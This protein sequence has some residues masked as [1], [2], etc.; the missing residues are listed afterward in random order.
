MP[1]NGALSEAAFCVHVWMPVF[2]ELLHSQYEL[3]SLLR[4]IVLSYFMY[5]FNTLSNLF[6][7]LE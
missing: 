4:L 7:D 5:L 3:S 2:R 6:A 1:K